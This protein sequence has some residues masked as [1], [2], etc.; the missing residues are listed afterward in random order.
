MNH[1]GCV[2]LVSHDAGGAELLASYAAKHK[3]GGPFVLAGPAVGVFKRR[4][5]F[6]GVSTLPEALAACEWCLCGTSW[7]SDLEWNA[8]AEARRA[9]KRAVAFLDHWI[10]YRERFVRNGILHLPDEIWVADEYAEKLAHNVFGGIDLRLVSNPYFAD[11]KREIAKLKE[12]MPKANATGKTILFVSE[13]ISDGER[14]LHGDE[15][16]RGYTEFD[17]ISYLLDNLKAFGGTINKVVIRPH[18]SDSSGKYAHLVRSYPGIVELSNG[19][20]LVKEIAEADV[21]AGCQSMALVVGLLAE[22]VVVSCIPPGGDACLLPQK[23]IL[24][25]KNLDNL[26]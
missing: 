5:G 9:G 4:L 18:P 14:L 11:L 8:I 7:Q 13:N 16:Y 10:N 23:E 15:R 6:C 2:A 3:L 1:A 25:L 22:K 24:H 17:A 20:P 26:N 21:V 19:A 12:E